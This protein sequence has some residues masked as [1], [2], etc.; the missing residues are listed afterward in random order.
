MNSYSI[1]IILDVLKSWGMPLL[2]YIISLDK[3]I[4]LTVYFTL[5]NA[6]RMH[7]EFAL[8]LQEVIVLARARKT[9]D[10]PRDFSQVP[11][12]FRTVREKTVGSVLFGIVYLR[13]ISDGEENRSAFSKF[14]VRGIPKNRVW[15]CPRSNRFETLA[16]QFHLA[17]E[18]GA[19]DRCR[20]LELSQPPF[21]DPTFVVHPGNAL[22]KSQKPKS[23]SWPKLFDFPQSLY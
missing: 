13:A 23:Q 22:R 21:C 20:R 8:R 2:S 16:K 14:V 9:F 5:V 6:L 17:I 10:W 3:I 15:R 18:P 4:N 1:L 12:R 11:K 7:Y 19:R